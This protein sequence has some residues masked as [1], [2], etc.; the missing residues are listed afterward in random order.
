MISPFRDPFS[1]FR[2]DTPD[3]STDGSTPTSPNMLTDK[4]SGQVFNV[5]NLL[6]QGAFKRV[7]EAYAMRLGQ[8]TPTRKRSPTPRALVASPF[9]RSRDSEENQLK[10]IT[11]EIRIVKTINRL[12][13]K[14]VISIELVFSDAETKKVYYIT[15]LYKGP[16]NSSEF[17]S[18]DEMKTTFKQMGETIHKLHENQIVHWDLKPENILIDR[19]ERTPV[20]IDFGCSWKV[21]DPTFPKP[22]NSAGTLIYRSPNERHLLQDN[23]ESPY[24]RDVY[25]LAATFYEVYTGIS[26]AESVVNNLKS[27][28]PNRF[29]NEIPFVYLSNATEEIIRETI[30]TNIQDE[31]LKDL[32]QKMLC[33]NSEESE[34]TSAQEF[35]MSDVLNHP[36]FI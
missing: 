18:K 7:E 3:F 17:T 22:K 25:A 15:P 26:L 6:G 34:E 31:N 1:P 11:Q 10:Q 5:G 16:L 29:S 36:Y 33:L 32:L 24:A 21:G 8:N 14:G 20:V 19:E 9:N 23:E 12:N 27:K 2:E 30:E 35:R 28:Y 4:K 13:I